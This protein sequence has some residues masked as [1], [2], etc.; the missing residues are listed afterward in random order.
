QLPPISVY[1]DD[2][3]L[4]FRPTA[5]EASTIKGLLTLFGEATGLKTNFCKSTI[6]PIQCND[7]QRAMVEAILSCRVEDFPITYQG[8]PL[9]TRKPTK[10]EVQPILDKLA[11]KVAGWKPKMLSIDGRLCLIKSMLMAL[12]VHYMSVL[13][14]P[15]WAIKDI[16]RKCRGFLWKGQEEVSGGHCLVSWR[17]VCSPVEKGGFGVK[18]MNFFG[19]AL[20]LKWHA[21]SLE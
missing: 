16:E 7:Q 13:Q 15:R 8:L 9:G 19:R 10:A 2:A 14:L 3:V 21:K 18:D 4:F 11:K 1:A 17:K 5:G 12:P 6:T 20:R